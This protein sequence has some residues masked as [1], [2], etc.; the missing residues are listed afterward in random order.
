MVSRVGPKSPFDVTLSEYAEDAKV[1]AKKFSPPWI[2]GF[3]ERNS[4]RRR[5]VS[6]TD[7]VLPPVEEVQKTMG[8]I[9]ETKTSGDFRNDET[10]SADETAV[11]YGL[12]PKNQYVPEGDGRGSAPASDE[13]A[14]YT[15]M[16]AGDGDGGMLASFNIIKC[17]STKADLTGTRVLKD[18]HKMSGF[19][20][21]DGWEMLTWSRTLTLLD[22]KKKEFT[23][24]S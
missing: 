11:L 13:K 3:I 7:K 9:A 20:E 24:E 5:A 2:K 14:R 8:D 19:T 16:Q 15:S 17:S 18:L 10:V 4:L 12:Q 1:Q 23:A 22:K 21:A 6:T